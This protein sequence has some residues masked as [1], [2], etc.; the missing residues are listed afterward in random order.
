[1]CRR[2]AHYAKSRD[3]YHNIE[4]INI[5]NHAFFVAAYGDTGLSTASLSESISFS[6]H[7]YTL[8]DDA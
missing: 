6:E 8:E 1:M 5:T 2:E 3:H 7:P 4:K